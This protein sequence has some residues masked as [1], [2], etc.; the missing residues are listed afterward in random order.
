MS[1]VTQYNTIYFEK[2]EDFYEGAYYRSY[3]FTR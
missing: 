2:L 3:G 1:F